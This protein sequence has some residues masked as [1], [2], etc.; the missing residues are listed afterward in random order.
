[1]SIVFSEKTNEQVMSHKYSGMNKQAI[2]RLCRYER[3]RRSSDSTSLAKVGH[4]GSKLKLNMRLTHDKYEV[5]HAQHTDAI[6]VP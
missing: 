2:N 5:G 1:M 3:D 6:N 4:I